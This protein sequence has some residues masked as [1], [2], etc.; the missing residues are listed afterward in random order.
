ML[1]YELETLEGLDED[2]AAL[3]EKSGDKFRLKIK[4]L[5]IP[6]VSGLKRKVDQLLDEKKAAQKAAKDAQKAA[7]QAAAEQA[8]KDGDI[9]AVEKGLRK[10]FGSQIAERDEAITT[11][12]GQLK[13]LLVHG[14]ATRIATERAV[15]TD[16]IPIVAEWIEHRLDMDV[17]DGEYKTVVRGSDGKPN[18]LSV[19]EFEQGLVKEKSL[20][21]LLKASDA[22]GGGAKGGDHSSG[23]AQ[24][25]VTR[26]RFDGMTHTQRSEFSK[27]G[28]KVVND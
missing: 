6:D 25:T 19:D 21:R 16:S 1:T 13:K 3:Y 17:R 28:G 26:S 12:S 24:K 14:E 8:R 10:E 5:E 9:E 18:G 4:G 20:A 22:A 27:S 15:D 2:Q 23:A 7:E 11:L